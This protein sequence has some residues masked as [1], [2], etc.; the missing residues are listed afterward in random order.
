LEQLAY[1]C[2][3]L[4]TVMFAPRGVCG[5]LLASWRRFVGQS[6]SILPSRPAQDRLADAGL[7]SPSAAEVCLSVENVSQAFGGVRA[8]RDVSFAVRRGEVFALVGPNGAGKTTLFNIVSGVLQPTAGRIFVAGS[9]ITG[10]A[11]HRRAALIGRSFQNPRLV[12]ELSVLANVM[13]RVDQIA[14]GLA[15]RG[16]E[17]VAQAQL[18]IFDLGP[19]ARQAVADISLGQRKLIDIARAAAGNPP[20]VLLDEP[21]VGLTADELVHLSETIRKLRKS[22]CAVVIVEHNVAFISDIAERGIVLDVG[23]EI[24]AGTVREIMAE[25]GVKAAYFGALP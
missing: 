2:A 22:G 25:E 9:D 7:R 6:A 13:L 24:A 20:L 19:L 4:L 21:A 14:P 8:L 12:P 23:R 18:E 15:E 5:L 1:G 11:V 3:F 17:A 16:R 10:T